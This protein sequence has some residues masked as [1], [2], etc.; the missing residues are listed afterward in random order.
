M[1]LAQAKILGPQ[2]KVLKNILI[3]KKMLKQALDF[4]SR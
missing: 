3:F 2:T 1:L 4:V